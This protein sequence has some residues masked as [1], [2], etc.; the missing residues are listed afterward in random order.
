MP[1]DFFQIPAHGGA[2][3]A[4]VLNR[5]LRSGRIA[6][7]RKEFV[8]AEGA[9]FWAF[10]V[11]YIDGAAA[12]SGARNASK[13]AKV[14]YRE[15][16]PEAELQGRLCA[17]TAFTLPVCSYQ[18]RQ[19]VLASFRSVAIGHEPRA[20][21][22]QLEQQREQLPCRQQQRL[23]PR[24]QLRPTRADRVRASHQGTEPATDP[25][26]SRWGKAATAIA[27]ASSVVE[28]TSNARRDGHFFQVCATLCERVH[29]VAARLGN[30]PPK[31]NHLNFNPYY[32][33]NT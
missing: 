25:T 4:E 2:E 15:L 28:A 3:A 12:P 19:R 30:C 5:R 33:E 31:P 26:P 27:R 10:C 7:V 29:A 22:W 6:A 1:Y 13:T 16:L 9:A 32:Y 20:T 8:L 14:D 18:Y 21:G 23:P 11:E 17:L 24:P